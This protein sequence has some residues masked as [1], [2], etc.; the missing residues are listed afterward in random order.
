MDG[1][2]RMLYNGDLR[3]ARTILDLDSKIK[4]KWEK[5][6]VCVCADVFVCMSV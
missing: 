4:K 5:G 6:C 2:E 3:F 1:R